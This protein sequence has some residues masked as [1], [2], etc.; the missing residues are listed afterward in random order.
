MKMLAASSGLLLVLIVFFGGCTRV[1]TY[2]LEA[3]IGTY[4]QQREAGSSDTRLGTVLV[5]RLREDGNSPK[6]SVAFTLAGPTGFTPLKET[7]PAG[8]EWIVVPLL[9][10][11]P[12]AGQ[13]RLELS[14]G[15][16]QTLELNDA[17]QILPLTTI[18]ATLENNTVNVSWENVAKAVGYYVRLF[19]TANGSQ[20]GS[21][22]Y[23]LSTQ[24]QFQ[25]VTVGNLAVVVYA[26]NFDS[27]ANDPS[28]PDQV[29]VSDSIAS[30]KQGTGLQTTSTTSCR[31]TMV[32]KD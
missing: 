2:T 5:I 30:V 1:P 10:N 27:V 23:T 14:S 16:T 15:L 7:Y 6:T 3:S 25:N 21:T 19:N 13:Y 18:T 12:L 9:Q 8:S 29:L 4:S 28:L 17:S 11:A 31:A 26:T 24:A 32:A 22:V 20:V